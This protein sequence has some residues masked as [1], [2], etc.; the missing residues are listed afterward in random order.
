MYEHDTWP[1]KFNSDHKWSFTLGKELK[2]PRSVNVLEMIKKVN[3]MAVPQKIEIIDEFYFSYG[4][5]FD[6]TL[7]P[8]AECCI[9]IILRKI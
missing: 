5:D 6:Q 2:L 8:N 1:S 9:E 7:L 3:H 4:G